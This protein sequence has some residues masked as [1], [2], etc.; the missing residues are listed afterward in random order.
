MKDF[1]SSLPL[2]TGVAVLSLWAAAML[3]ETAIAAPAMGLSAL[4][5]PPTTT[6][7]VAGTGF[8][9]SAL[10]DIYF[11]TTD[12][13]LAVASDA[14]AISCVIKVPKDAQPQTHYIS[15]IQR[16]TGTGAQKSFQV[17]TDWAQFHGRDA[18][19]T[20]FNPYENTLNTSNVAGLDILW[21]APIG[22]SGT[23]GTPVVSG[24]KVYIGGLD[25]K[26]YAF[27]TTTGTAVGVFPKTLGGSVL[28][29][30]PAVGQGNVYIGTNAPDSKLYAF[31]ANTG[32]TTAGYPVTLGGAIYA[33]PTLYNGNVYVGCL[34]GKI[35]AFAA[36]AGTPLAG[37]PLTANAAINAAVSAANG[38]IY[39][40]SFSNGQFYAF[41]A[42]TGAAIPGY[43]RTTGDSIQSTAAL[44]SGQVFFNSADNNLYGLHKSD[45]AP[46]SG[47]PVATGSSVISSPASDGGQVVV[48]SSD[49]KIYSFSA[50]DGSLRWSKTLDGAVQ[51]SPIIAN[52]V[53]YVNTWRSLMALDAST[54][55][56]LWRAGVY[57]GALASPTV[58]DGIVFIGSTDGNLY[59]FSVNGVAPSSRL[60]G[61]ELGIKPALSSLKPN[62][63]LRAGGKAPG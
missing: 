11:D 31:N 45:G 8:S 59:A 9:A 20:G 57:T 35:Y 47:F 48:G 12:L 34:D 53:V 4:I 24:S 30:S 44:V 32:A 25:G 29:S 27:S 14:G 22:A 40:G 46:L 16:N 52:G 17:R 7:T 23:N 58:A 41:D 63:S 21:Q 62:Y 1:G 19:H 42:V 18:K 26:L 28:Y 13:C 50:A 3:C 51:G 43:P 49:Q 5:G 61:G 38:R 56:I 55:A 60:A 15:A 37:F 54:G 6:V 2:K 36:A 10:V 33:P 39:A